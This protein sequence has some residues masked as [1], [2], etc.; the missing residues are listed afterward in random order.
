MTK[1]VYLAIIT[2]S[3]FL[4]IPLTSNALLNIHFD[5]FTAMI[6]L[7]DGC[8]GRPG[9]AI[10][11][12]LLDGKEVFKSDV[13][14]PGEEPKNIVI[15]LNEAKILTLIVDDTGDGHGG[16]WGN[17]ADARLI[18][19]ES[20]EVMFLS[21]L[22]AVVEQR[23]IDTQLDRNII[24][25][26]I[27]MSGKIYAKGLG[28]ISGSRMNYSGW[29]ETWNQKKAELLKKDKKA[30][31]KLGKPFIS[32]TF[33]GRLSIT[34]NGNLKKT[35]NN[36]IQHYLSEGEKIAIGFDTESGENIFDNPVIKSLNVRVG[37]NITIPITDIIPTQ[38]VYDIP[39]GSYISNK[40]I[41]VLNGIRYFGA[42]GTGYSVKI[43]YE[44]LATQILERLEL[45][46]SASKSKKKGRYLVGEIGIESWE[47]NPFATVVFSIKLDGKTVYRSGLITKYSSSE[48]ISI[49]FPNSKEL[50]LIV[51][52]FGDGRYHDNAAWADI[53]IIEKLPQK[54]SN[55]HSGYVKQFPLSSFIPYILESGWGRVGIDF[56]A[57]G[58]YINVERKIYKGGFGVYA[59]SRIIFKNLDNAIKTRSAAISEIEKVKE[60]LKGS[61]ELIA[62]EKNI[63]RAK[64]IDDT[65]SDIYPIL[66]KIAEAK[67]DI[68]SAIDAWER[69]VDISHA[70][71]REKRMA[72]NIIDR[73]YEKGD[74]TKFSRHAV[75]QPPIFNHPI[76]AYAFQNTIFTVKVGEYGEEK[77]TE[78]LPPGSFTI[79]VGKDAA[80]KYCSLLVNARGLKP[81]LRIAK[82]GLENH[83]SQAE[84]LNFSDP[85]P[86]KND[87][88]YQWKLEEGE[89]TIFVDY[90]R[91]N[92]YDNTCS[93]FLA[94]SL[95]DEPPS[96]PSQEWEYTIFNTGE[97]EVE[98]TITGNTLILIPHTSQDLIVG[99]AQHY[100]CYPLYEYGSRL[101][102]PYSM[103]QVLMIVPRQGKAVVTFQWLDAAYNVPMTKYGSDRKDTFYF[104]SIQGIDPSVEQVK[105]SVSVPEGT[106]EIKLLV[107][108]TKDV[109]GNV[110]KWDSVAWDKTVTINANHTS[111]NTKW[112]SEK[113][114]NMTVYLPDNP[115]NRLWMPEYMKML[116]RIY[117]RESFLMGDY[118][119]ETETF[120][121]V[122]GPAQ[123]S[124][125]GGATWGGKN[126]ETWIASTGRIGEYHLRH[127]FGGSG[128][129][130]HELKWVFCG[131]AIPN[132]PRWL[133]WGN[134]IWLEEQGKLAGNLAFP[135]IWTR[136]EL[137]PQ[138]RRHLDLFTKPGT[139]YA[140]F[141]ND[142][143]DKLTNEQKTMGDAMIW[144]I[145]EYLYGKY[146]ENLFPEFWKEIRKEP[147]AY[148]A[149]DPRSRIIKAVDTLV[150]ISGD[151]NVRKQFEK[152]GFDLKPDPQYSEKYFF[153][154]PKEWSF[155]T[156]D[157]EKWSSKDFDDSAWEK[158]TVGKP[159]EDVPAYAEYD[160]FAWYR[161]RFRFP[162]EF[163]AENMI[164]VLGK[165]DDCDE[166]FLNGIKIGETGTMPPEYSSSWTAPRK[167]PLPKE[168]VRI[169]DENVIAVRVYDGSGGGG[170]YER[171]PGIMSL[172]TK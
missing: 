144:H 146:G 107:P 154:L 158:I 97:A 34:V 93:F 152:W 29:N 122:T 63:I 84:Y 161:L 10:F 167:Y 37:K 5:T 98:C 90:S 64:S 55:S 88:L 3:L 20:G 106:G 25:E 40:E 160:G 91:A 74:F 4:I 119:P 96:K 127:Q 114:R 151:R 75:N 11:R 104:K 56:S 143:F 19:N 52:D 72:R 73:L 109:E 65:V 145:F 136:T 163:V 133:N 172:L 31:K 170:I 116:G 149:L 54:S 18:D 22:T 41:V 95:S 12:V 21:D 103:G 156:G 139:G 130:A 105:I 138:S 162:P 148:T 60:L 102:S 101:D 87:Y 77:D 80:G 57:R 61:T 33:S 45:N 9:A 16:D 49:P 165:I 15:S 23:W 51:S 150:K 169:N 113:H 134:V 79:S 131:G 81:V 68:Q 118:E 157:D 168:L 85:M 94:Y 117:D 53:A 2:F 155:K 59:P 123:L 142:E 78:I 38:I 89:W 66:G 108:E 13:M 140:P 17:W 92:G 76:D 42:T 35:G 47:K 46:R 43:V 14:K 67:G 99:D 112:L 171:T 111:L 100:L 135:D 121:Y 120:I 50:E 7:D 147:D 110:Y 166:V 86:S 39:D 129:E 124:G 141:D 6:G 44:N 62:V 82:A 153:S 71:R 27:N 128:V 126:S 69:V 83:K 30:L 8:I 24:Q 36:K 48:T 115:Y 58:E 26:P 137:I 164:I 132:L 159:W 28:A 32:G 1:A 70:T 125:Y